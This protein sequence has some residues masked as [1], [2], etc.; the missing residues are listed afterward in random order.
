MKKVLKL[1]AIALVISGSTLIPTQDTQAF[2]GGN[3]MPWNWFDDYPYYGNYYPYYPP[4]SY[5]GYYPYYGGGYPY[6]S[7]YPYGYYPYNGGWW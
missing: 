5:Y 6:G 2:W 7:Y 3:W 1:L 4:Y